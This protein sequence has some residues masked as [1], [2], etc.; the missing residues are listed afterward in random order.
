MAIINPF[1][2]QLIKVETQFNDKPL[3]LEINRLAFRSQ[4][5]VLATYGQ[6]VV[7]G[8]VNVGQANPSMD[9]F[10]LTVDYEER[11]YA[12]GKISGSRYIKR[13][14]RPSDEA[15]LI[16]RMID[17]PIRPLFPKGYRQEVQA[18]AVVLSLDPQ[19][20]PDMVATLAISSAMCLTGAPF[21]GP[22]SSVRVGLVDQQLVV[23][24]DAQ[25]REASQLDMIVAS[26]RAGV[27]MVEAAAT[28]VDEDT[29]TQAL[30]E[31]HQANQRL[32]D[33]QE[34]LIEQVQPEPLSYELA[35]PTDDIKQA[36]QT[37]CDQQ[38]NVLPVDANYAQR[39]A[40]EAAL[41]EAFDQHFQTTLTADVY[42]DQQALYHDALSLHLDQQVRQQIVTKQIR[43][44]GRKL[45]EVRPLSSQVGLLPR[46]HGSALFTRGATQALNIVTLA[47]PSYAQALDTMEYE[48]EKHYLHHYVAPGYTLGE[49]KRIGS[50]GRRE[51]G[52]S[53]LAEKALQAV[54]P[55][56]VD[57]PYTVRSVTE[58]LSQHGST[59]MAATC[60][61]CLALMDAGVPIKAPVAGVA[62]GLMLTADQTPLILTDIADAEDFAGDMDFKVAGTAQGITALQMDMKVPGLPVAILK[63]ALQ[64]AVP[65]RATIMEHMLS[66]LKAPR[67]NLNP[68]APRVATLQIAVSKIKDVIGKGGETIHALT[69]STGAQIDVKDDG[70]ILIFSHNQKA[71]QDAVAQIKAL[72][73]DPEVGR[74]YYNRPIVKILDFGVFVNL[75]QGHD[76]MVHV[77]EL[78]EQHVR[79]P[80]DV[81][82]E[83]DLVNVKLI[84]IDDNGRLNLSMKRVSSKV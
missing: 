11:F 40:A 32:L 53:Y 42:A 50:P 71:L 69:A 51:I 81:C 12:A 43:L 47:P 80:A 38:A 84:A 15:I 22:V 55:A 7:L 52:H 14:G 48:G 74:I 2:K 64:A 72:T 49:V 57:F 34:Q 67:E 63:Q 10:P 76:G 44:D 30:Q 66:I 56:Q 75:S 24:P 18:V 13:E 45:D 39:L 78:S 4:A 73:D 29:V 27:M 1:G 8:T 70:Q 31:A 35:L 41:K 58:I 54:M 61:S 16:G 26:N 79:H 59:S 19:V 77:S 17:R 25:Q 5:S 82:K 60:A 28:E 3:S 23:C 9:Y 65:A 36:V 6:T 33:L 21:A 62:M 68:E 37:W 20:R 46:T 83:G